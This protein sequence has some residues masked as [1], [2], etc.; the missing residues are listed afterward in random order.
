MDINA[1]E[2]AFTTTKFWVVRQGVKV[3]RYELGV[4]GDVLGIGYD[5]LTD[6]R[7]NFNVVG[8]ESGVLR[9]IENRRYTFGAEL[10]CNGSR[11]EYTGHGLEDL[12][13]PLGLMERG[14]GG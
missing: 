12:T 13:G 1:D 2:L 5:M 4:D 3:F 10:L 8:G 7:F 14:H 11:G 6:R 9:D